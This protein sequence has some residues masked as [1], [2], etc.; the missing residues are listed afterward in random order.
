MGSTTFVRCSKQWGLPC[1]SRHR[2]GKPHCFEHL[3]FP[4]VAIYETLPWPDRPIPSPRLPMD[5]FEREALAR[6]PL[7]EAVL[8]LW[9]HVTDPDCLQTIFDTHRGLSYHKELS[10]ETIV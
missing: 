10:F 1:R 6:L 3:L 8:H 9:G 5:A 7:A 2:Q 4:Q